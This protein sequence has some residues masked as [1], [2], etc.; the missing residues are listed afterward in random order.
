MPFAARAGDLTCHGK[1]LSPGL[2]SINVF[3]GKKPA[4]RA[5]VDA[6]VC[7]LVS[8]TVPHVGGV[9][10]KGSVTVFINKFPAARQGDKIVE[11]GP[12]NTIAAGYP[13]V[14]IGG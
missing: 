6:H 14:S 4:W 10:V 7:P 13:T 8:G 3:I 9:V 11:A 5:L 2:G 1:P 12:P